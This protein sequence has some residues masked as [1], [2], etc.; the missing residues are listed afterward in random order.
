MA[1][2]VKMSFP[3]FS[4]LKETVHQCFSGKKLLAFQMGHVFAMG[5]VLWD[6]GLAAS[7]TLSTKCQECP[8]SC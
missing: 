2:S 8:I 7:L 4:V 3:R 5:A 6:A 1:G